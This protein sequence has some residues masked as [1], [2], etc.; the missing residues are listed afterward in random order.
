MALAASLAALVASAGC[1]SRSARSEASTQCSVTCVALPGQVFAG[2]MSAHGDWSTGDP[3]QR[4]PWTSS[5]ERA[6]GDREA[7]LRRCHATRRR[8]GKS[9]STR[10]PAIARRGPLTADAGSRPGQVPGRTH[11]RHDARGPRDA[12]SSRC[13]R[14]KKAREILEAWVRRTAHS[15]W[16]PRP[17]PVRYGR[18]TRGERSA[19]SL[20]VAFSRG[21]SPGRRSRHD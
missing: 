19:P 16:P 1:G 4:S 13:E 2:S 14:C 21:L 9:E 7:P 11:V 5:T 10:S 8:H 15:R 6:D 18:E 17:S 3:S 12:T 20:Q